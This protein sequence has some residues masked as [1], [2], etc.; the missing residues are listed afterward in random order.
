[1]THYEKVREA[2]RP[3]GPL[4]VAQHRILFGCCRRPDDRTLAVRVQKFILLYPQYA[5]VLADFA[6]LPKKR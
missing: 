6:S 2:L 5:P 4:S 3:F 1:M